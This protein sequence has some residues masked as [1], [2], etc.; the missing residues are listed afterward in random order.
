MSINWSKD[1]ILTRSDALYA[2]N[3]FADY[4]SN[5]NHITDYYK[6]VKKET[7]DKLPTPMFG[8]SPGDEFFQS[9]D[10]PPN[11]MN[12]AL[13]EVSNEVFR[14]YLDITASHPVSD[15][16]PGRHVKWV[17][18]ETNTNTIVGFIRL[19]S[20][21]IT[22][23]PRN[24]YL[25]GTVSAK[26]PITLANFN[27]HCINGFIIVPTQPFGFNYLG[28]KLLA[29]LCCTSEAREF[30]NQRY[31]MNTCL[32]ETTSLYGSSKESSQ[33]DGMR[34]FIR[35]KGLT[36]SSFSP[37]LLGSTY[38]NLCAWFTEKNNNVRIVD[39]SASG[40]KL[41]T[42]MRMIAIIKKSLKEH[43][44]NEYNNFITTMK[45]S[46]DL[47]EQKRFFISEYGYENVPQVIRGE[48]SELRPRSNFDRFSIKGVTAW[49]KNKATKR[50]NNL[51]NDGR[52]RTKLEIWSENSDI[53]I[54]R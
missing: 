45:H 23:R 39:P 8:M 54:V 18:K 25:N 33:Y 36:Q 28:G 11:D 17:V 41:K 44:G 51:K 1:L 47:T 43:D 42:Q 32:F 49:W 2:A 10:M 9:W 30:I 34:P 53:D 46:E 40:R 38:H 29:G 16:V 27:K 4:F 14:S 35:F 22:I 19:G 6:E 20:P 31:D 7:L 3:I 21:V 50:Y 13:V 15:S 12:F 48:E 52:F 24:E 5:F 37:L 26:G